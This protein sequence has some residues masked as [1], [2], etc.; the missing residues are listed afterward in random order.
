MPKKL[1]LSKVAERTGEPLKIVRNAAR[2]DK[3]TGPRHLKTSL[4]TDTYGQP[5]RKATEEEADRW[6][7]AGKNN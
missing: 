3:G 6:H 5:V 4:G 1:T 7:R 2:T